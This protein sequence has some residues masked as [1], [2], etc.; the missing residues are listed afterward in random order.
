MV[1]S[2]GYYVVNPEIH[3][4]T[5]IYSNICYTKRMDPITKCPQKSQ[6]CIKPNK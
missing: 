6:P 1:M 4:S 5:D 2:L 3:W